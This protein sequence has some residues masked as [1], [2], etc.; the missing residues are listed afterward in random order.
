MRSRA[1]ATIKFTL[2]GVVHDVNHGPVLTSGAGDMLI[3]SWMTATFEGAFGVCAA[4]F[5]SERSRESFII[6]GPDLRWVAGR[7]RGSGKAD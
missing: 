6:I 3:V 2:D 7:R 1:L 5:L 4:V